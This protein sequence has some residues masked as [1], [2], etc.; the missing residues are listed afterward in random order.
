MDYASLISNPTAVYYDSAVGNAKPNVLLPSFRFGIHN[1]SVGAIVAGV[2]GIEFPGTLAYTNSSHASV[3]SCEDCHMASITGGS[4][5]HTFNAKGNFNG[6]NTVACHGAGGLN[7]NSATFV[8]DRNQTQGLL[9]T[10]ASKLKSG[11]VIFIHTDPTSTNLWANI[12]PNSYDGNLNIYD[13]SVNPGGAFRNPAP[14]KSWTTA[15]ISSNNALPKFTSL[16][17]VQ[18]GAII[19]FQLCLREY[20][21]GI[22]NYG[23]TVA[24]LTNTIAALT[25]AGY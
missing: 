25:A 11:G 20:S 13:P 15:N 6:C 3:A 4:G 8:N 23:Y 14:A 9:L 17:N 24:L 12:T 19:N 22:H 21:L 2:G 16:T 10:L 7:S 18:M 1:G 5:G